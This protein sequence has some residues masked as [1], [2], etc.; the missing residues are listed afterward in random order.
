MAV[1]MIRDMQC[2]IQDSFWKSYAQ[3]FQSNSAKSVFIATPEKEA[4]IMQLVF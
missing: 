3:L 2:A 1:G 4:E